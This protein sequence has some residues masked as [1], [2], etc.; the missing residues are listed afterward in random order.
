[1]ERSA[2]INLMRHAL[3]L[4]GN[5]SAGILEAPIIPLGVVNVGSRQKGRHATDNVIFVGESRNQIKKGIETVLSNKFKIILKN[6]QS[7]Y[8]NGKSIDKAYCLIKRLDIK[9]YKYK[10]EDPLY[11]E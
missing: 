6:V 7:P 1:M 5:S 2:F 9:S 10:I 8:G 11:N 4:I 3:F